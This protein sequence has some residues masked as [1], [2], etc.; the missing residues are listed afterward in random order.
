MGVCGEPR[1]CWQV[2]L[3]AALALSTLP[4]D[5]LARRLVAV[6]GGCTF[7][8]KARNAQ[9]AGASAQLVYYRFN[10]PFPA[11]DRQAQSRAE[12]GR[13]EV[14]LP[15]RASMEVVG[16]GFERD[17]THSPGRR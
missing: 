2:R 15:R 13:R 5:E 1:R 3:G 17:T 12:I 8:K 6:R 4:A 7:V 14:L 16:S 10:L 11:W 9:A